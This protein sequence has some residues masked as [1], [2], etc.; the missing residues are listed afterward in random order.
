M[1]VLSEH[2][3]IDVLFT[4]V[5]MPGEICGLQLAVKARKTRPELK[6]FLTT[7]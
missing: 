7:L 4:D 2:E 1:Q 5:I 6:V 3:T